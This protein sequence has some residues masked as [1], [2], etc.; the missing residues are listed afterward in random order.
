[1]KAPVPEARLRFRIEQGPLPA[2]EPGWPLIKI[3][4]SGLCGS[5]LHFYLGELDAPPDLV[6]GHEMAGVIVDAG[7]TEL[8]VGQAV[9]VCPMIGCGTCHACQRGEYHIC[10]KLKVIGSGDY[11]G[12][13]AEYVAAPGRLDEACRRRLARQSAALLKGTVHPAETQPRGGGH[14]PPGTDQIWSE[15]CPARTA[16]TSPDWPRTTRDNRSNT[17]RVA[18]RYNV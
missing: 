6:R 12:G 1:M 9:V 3:K 16:P 2:L 14:G 7:D 4:G 13:F 5:H 11:P 10:E 18:V 8:P 17:P 15:L